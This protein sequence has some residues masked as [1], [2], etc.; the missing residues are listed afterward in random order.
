MER[1]I[2]LTME[3][4]TSIQDAASKAEKRGDRI[5]D[6]VRK[7]EE[8]KVEWHKER[9]ALLERIAK[10]EDELKM[11]TKVREMSKEEK[12]KLAENRLE[13]EMKHVEAVTDEMWKVE[14]R[15]RK[16]SNRRIMISALEKG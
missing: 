5:K 3:Y 13:L 15:K 2:N 4:I 10:L 6:W 11:A 1:E 8:E 7:W 16:E 9:T 12:I 14:V